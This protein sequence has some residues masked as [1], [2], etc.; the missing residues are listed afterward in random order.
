MHVVVVAEDEPLIRMVVA[1][2]L[3]DEGFNVWEAEHAEE[4]LTILEAE[5]EGVH[6]LFTDVWMPGAMD[7]LALSHHVRERWPWIGLLVTSAHATLT[8]D[9][10]PKGGRFLPK[11]YHHHHVVQHVRELVEAA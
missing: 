3:A 2:L 5:A 10:L 6:V 7:G 9:D 4:A 11:P 1:Q 8:E